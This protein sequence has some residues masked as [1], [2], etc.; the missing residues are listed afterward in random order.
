MAWKCHFCSIL[1]DKEE[2]DYQTG[3]SVDKRSLPTMT[4]QVYSTFKRGLRWV[5]LAR[6]P[7]AQ[8]TQAGSF[9]IPGRTGS[10]VDISRDCWEQGMFSF[11]Q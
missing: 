5:N 1:T 4:I 9:L 11:L 8:L 3:H 2:K 6:V 10:K 7:N